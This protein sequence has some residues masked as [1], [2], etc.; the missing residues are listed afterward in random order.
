[1]IIE[2]NAATAG[3]LNEEGH[4]AVHG[5]AGD[6]DVLRRAGLGDAVS[7]ILSAPVDGD[8]AELIRMARADQS[9]NLRAR[10]LDV[11]FPGRGV[12]RGGSR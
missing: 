10:A 5:D 4:P 6:E 9:E 2:R 8:S 12:A 11:S 3:R 1:M 7:L